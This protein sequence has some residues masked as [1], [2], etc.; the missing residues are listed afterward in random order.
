MALAYFVTFSSIHLNCLDQRKDL[1]IADDRPDVD[2][3]TLNIYETLRL[4]E[5]YPVIMSRH[6]MVRVN[7]LMK[8]IQSND[9][10]LAGQSSPSYRDLDR[11]SSRV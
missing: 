10:V 5:K 3:S 8:F 2:P 9:K 6:F 11:K 1:L 4:I 7:A